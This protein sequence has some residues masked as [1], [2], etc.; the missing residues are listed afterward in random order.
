MNRQSAKIRRLDPEIIQLIS[1]FVS[2][3]ESIQ[4]KYW[5]AG[6]TYA[7]LLKGKYRCLHRHWKKHDI[8]FHIMKKDRKIVK[9]NLDLLKNKGYRCTKSIDR[10]IVFKDVNNRII[11]FPYL[12][13]SPYDQGLFCYIGHGKRTAPHMQDQA[14][15]QRLYQHDIPKEFF[16]NDK[17]KIG[18]L[19][20]NVPDKKFVDFVY[21]YPMVKY[22]PSQYSHKI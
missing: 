4:I 14:I 12:Q 9:K 13:T 10:K 18:D 17:L 22:K 1:D 15:R 6:G 16:K 8:D 20:V 7:C 21:H 2:F 19:T 3:F 5:L 11:E